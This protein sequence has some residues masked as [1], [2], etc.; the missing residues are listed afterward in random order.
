MSEVHIALTIFVVTYVVIIS[1]KIHKTTIALAGGMLVIAFHVLDTE[2]AFEAIDLDVIFLLVGMMIIAN[3]MADT[4]VFR[5]MAIRSA[6]AANGSPIRVLILLCLITA[7]ASAFLDNV[8]TVV[9]MAPVT[10]VVADTLGVKAVP[11]LIAEVLASN[12][13]GTA[14]LIGDPPNILIASHADI[15][16]VTFFLNVG[17]VSIIT[18]AGFLV[19]AAFFARWKVRATPEQRERVMAIDESGMI[20]DPRLLRITL[21]VLAFTVLGFIMHGQLGYEPSM[22]ALAGGSVLM[23]VA[24]QEPHEVLRDIEWSTLFFFIGLFVLV[25]GLEETGL[26]E[27]IG[28]RAVDLTDGSTV[29]YSWYRFVDQPSFQQYEWSDAKKAKLQSFVE[30]IHAHWPID[31]DYMAPPSNGRL[32]ALDSSLLVI[33]PEGM[34]TGYVPIVTHQEDTD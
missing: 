13:G 22:V 14:T 30:K 15:D 7:V 2:Q 18:L 3:T 19:V 23:L 28:A 26:L 20:T 31:R 6:K 1:E 9:L 11:M 16:F 25:A 12:I 10:L 8:T 5:W 24:R 32:V 33:P 21:V 27:T 29:T 34:E 4:G 17:P